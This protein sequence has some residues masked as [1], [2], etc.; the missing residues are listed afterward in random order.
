M[1]E[2]IEKG[3]CVK[4]PDGRIARVRDVIEGV[5]RVRVRRKTSKS[6]QFLKLRKEELTKVTCPKGWM[7]PDGYNRYLKITLEKM[8]IRNQ[9]HKR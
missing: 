5:Y 7:S 4:I 9:K 6:H 8:R 3:D 2:E 1:L